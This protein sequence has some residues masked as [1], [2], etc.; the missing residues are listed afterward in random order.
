LYSGYCWDLVKDVLEKAG[1]PSGLLRSLSKEKH[2]SKIGW[3]FY[4][5]YGNTETLR[6]IQ[7]GKDHT[8]FL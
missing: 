4:S 6:H 2:I 7:R 5:S 3:S 8:T 1:R